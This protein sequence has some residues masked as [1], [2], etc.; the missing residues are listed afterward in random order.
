MHYGRN[1]MDKMIDGYPIALAML[2]EGKE[3]LTFVMTV[4]DFPQLQY[5]LVF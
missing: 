4:L 2:D 5:W 1:C 3:E